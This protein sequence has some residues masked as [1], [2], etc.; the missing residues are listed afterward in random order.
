MSLCLHLPTCPRPQ[1]PEAAELLDSA[2]EPLVEAVATGSPQDE[3]LVD[4]V[5]GGGAG[6]GGGWGYIH[7][8][9]RSEGVTRYNSIADA[10]LPGVGGPAAPMSGANELSVMCQRPVGTEE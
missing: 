3:E 8:Y 4:K 7:D 1:G 9:L 10:L 2:I 5:G 6:G